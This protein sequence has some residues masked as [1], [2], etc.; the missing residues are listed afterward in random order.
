MAWPI[1]PGSSSTR[2]RLRDEAALLRQR[3]DELV[4]ANP[5]H[6]T[7]VR[8]LEEQY[9]A[10][11]IMPVDQGLAGGRLPTADELVAEVER[12]LREQGGR[13]AGVRTGP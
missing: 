5:E 1:S 4:K 3:L 11:A 13:V 10:E 12:F 6:L 7:M 2:P 9:D 8:R